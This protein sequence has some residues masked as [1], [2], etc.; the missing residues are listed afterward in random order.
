MVWLA[1]LA[2]GS[3]CLMVFGL[4]MI[5]VSI[6]MEPIERKLNERAYRKLMEAR[7]R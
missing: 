4:L 5:G 7:R 2:F 3:V 1:A 6:I